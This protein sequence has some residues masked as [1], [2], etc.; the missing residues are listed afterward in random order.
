MKSF[1]NES[2]NYIKNA[3]IGD[4]FIV[5]AGLP[6]IAYSVFMMAA[7]WYKSRP[8]QGPNRWYFYIMAGYFFSFLNIF[9]AHTRL[10]ETRH[11]FA[12][13]PFNFLFWLGP[14]LFQFSKSKLYRN[15]RF[16]GKDLK[17]YI[18]PIAHTSFYVFAFFLPQDQKIGLYN[19]EYSSLY[20][21]F[22]EFSFGAIMFLYCYF[23]YRFIKH[24]QWSLT[25]ETPRAEIV[26]ISWLRRFF[27]LFFLSSFIHLGHGLFFICHAFI[28][29]FVIQNNYLE[30]LNILVLMICMIWLGLHAVI[31]KALP[32]TTGF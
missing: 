22:E 1:L 3:S 28:F 30:L 2:L 9:I 25:K 7:F 20:K 26:K 29:K 6:L 13:L 5:I 19:Q 8:L 16:S 17:H 31:M 27:K 4:V 18:I 12:F 14:L 32:K 21:P 11:F 24:E 10:I 15:F 23:G